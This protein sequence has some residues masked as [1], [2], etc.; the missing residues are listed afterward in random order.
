ML[1]LTRNPSQKITIFTSDGPI[2]VQVCKIGRHSVRV[3]V[4]APLEVRVLRSELVD[5]E[6]RPRPLAA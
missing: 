5:D 2:E 6:G 4:I 1:V 3:G